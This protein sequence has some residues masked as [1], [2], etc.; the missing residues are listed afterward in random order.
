M[1]VINDSSGTNQNL[2]SITIPDVIKYGDVFSINITTTDSSTPIVVSTNDSTI[3][4]INLSNNEITIIKVGTA[5]LTVTQGNE[6]ITTSSLTVEKKDLL[7]NV[8]SKSMV[9]GSN[10]PSFNSSFTGFVFGETSMILSGNFLYVITDS[11]SNVISSSNLPTSS[12]GT[13]TITV[14]MGTISSSKYNIIINTDIANLTI[15]KKSLSINAINTSMNY[16]ANV[17]ALVSY[18]G[19][20]NGDSSSSLS[21]E[22]SYSNNF[23]SSTNAGS[24]NFSIS[25]GSL[26][27]LNYSITIV[28]SSAILT[29][30]KVNLSISALVN[31][32]MAYGANVPVLV[33]H[34][35]FVNGETLSNLSG[36]L[37]YAIT[38]STTPPNIISYSNLSNTNSGSYGFVVSIGSLASSNY[39]INIVSPNSGTLV[40]NSISTSITNPDVSAGITYGSSLASFISGTS[41]LVNGSPISGT[42]TFR[43]GSS[44]GAILTSA[45]ILS[46][47]TNVYISFVPT[48]SNY[49]SSNKTVPITI[50]KYTPLISF[51]DPLA[52]TTYGTRI[53]EI[54]L[55]AVVAQLNGST[56]P[57]TISFRLDTSSGTLINTGTNNIPPVINPDGS[58]G[59]R[60]IVAI[61]TPSNT[62]LYNSASVSKNVT[63]NKGIIS[64][65]IN[66][67]SVLNVFVGQA[68]PTIPF[69]YTGFVSPDTFDNSISGTPTYIF[70]DGNQNL[71]PNA[72]VPS[73]AAG[74]YYIY[75]SIGSLTSDKYVFTQFP[76]TAYNINKYKVSVSYILATNLKTF[77]YGT[78]LTADYFTAT[79]GAAENGITPS[80]TINYYTNKTMMPLS[81]GSVID[82]DVT[83]LY[84]YFIPHSSVNTIYNNVESTRIT[85]TVNPLSP[86]VLSYIIPENLRNISY[87]T[88]L[89]AE[90]LNARATYNGVDITSTGR[91]TYRTSL[92]DTNTVYLIG[93]KLPAGTNTLYVFYTNDTNNYTSSNTTDAT[94]TTITVTQ[95]SLNGIIRQ[96]AYNML[97]STNAPVFTI[98]WT[99]FASGDN[100]IISIIGSPIYVI[101][102]S[103]NNDVT[104]TIQTQNI[105]AYVVSAS[106]GTLASSNYILTL[107]SATTNLNINPATP[108]LS[109]S[110]STY[111]YGDIAYLNNMNAV[112]NSLSVS[113]IY[114]LRLT[115]ASGSILNTS[116]YI[117]VGQSNIIYASFTP[118]SSNYLP[119]IQT[120]SNIIVTKATPI[121]SYIP[122]T[123]S[124]NY[125][126]TLTAN[127]L[128]AVATLNDITV[129]GSFTYTYTLNSNPS[130]TGTALSSTILGAGIYTL[131]ATFVPTD[132]S[133]FESSTTVSFSTLTVNKI[134]LTVSISTNIVRF[135]YGLNVPQSISYS[136]LGFV[137]S[138][139][140][141]IF[142]GQTPDFQVSSNNPQT[143]LITK[144]NLA[145][146]S[147]GTGYFIN[148]T[149]GTLISNNYN[150]VFGTVRSCY[151]EKANPT[152]TI[153]I[154]Q[155][156]RTFD[157]GT[158][159]TSSYFNGVAKVKDVN[160]NDVSITGTF[161]FNDY[162]KGVVNIGI[163]YLFNSG[164]QRIQCSFNPTDS[165]KYNSGWSN[166]IDLTVN[167]ITPVITYT[168]P[169]NFKSINYGSVF[170]S[171]QLNAVVTYN[172]VVVNTGTITYKPNSL[173]SL[174]NY[175][176][177]SYPTSDLIRI[178]A[179]FTD[180]NNNYNSVSAFDTITVN[181]NNATLT[182]K[183]PILQNIAYGTPLSN[184]QLCA[185]TFN[186]PNNSAPGI[187]NYSLSSNNAS[188]ALGQVLDVGTYVIKAIL[189][190]TNPNYILETLMIQNTLT[191]V[192]NIPSINWANPRDVVVGTAL[193]STQL[194]AV[195]SV[196]NAVS[197]Y[198]PVSGTVMNSATTS[199][200][201]PVELNVLATYDNPNFLF[202]SISTKVKLNVNN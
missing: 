186:D 39:N 88:V 196:S 133:N 89:T 157:Y 131:T 107:S 42:F 178:Y 31:V 123:Q 52:T 148:A 175:T 197:T 179:I 128:N 92:T 36:V 9:Y 138:D 180:S 81:V 185:Q 35:G 200:T 113:G 106:M 188:I 23:S 66:N 111:V 193:S 137:N 158:G 17:P 14:S 28:S 10:A 5:T 74:S 25:I 139:T 159:L 116:N 191:I 102:D 168:I 65:Q 122:T 99:G 38:D 63:I 27:S 103:L 32:S 192:K 163:G 182:W 8:N 55:S 12:V 20:V 53:G 7:V 118:T 87:G 154:A 170:V 198:T 162:F 90:Q 82:A 172:G 70:K 4:S 44:N 104:S 29:I 140:S 136:Y 13:Y 62:T 127:N 187:I 132:T 46:A 177:S 189:V 183:Y 79:Y 34:S 67:R 184:Y 3:F 98:D 181:T 150:F 19:F 145:S 6:S 48:S 108:V 71:I 72:N 50:N 41:V 190:V 49:I 201:G 77:N 37:S 96:T 199:Q 68:I 130:I 59:T 85:I 114:V 141:T 112:Y 155:N 195:V 22:L 86:V 142:S 73:L 165:S 26:D 134:D 100:S 60:T 58:I 153:T 174:T 160:N 161:V 47:T 119:R 97:Y 176:T 94:N 43:S 40:I 83:S 147:V 1:T 95:S 110:T 166:I 164:A 51:N 15:T 146:S 126:D 149:Q 91:I 54:V 30:N 194:N 129:N 121:L 124:Y 57:G 144:D 93:S 135:Y 76:A 61:F 167:K 115:N 156:L 33:S 117:P 171:S 109:I 75:A 120:I 56:I 2:T 21:G 69:N 18:S 173:S 143:T 101:K 78:A 24:N 16:G 202:D 80:G 84:A 105:G 151:I 64:T 45:S 125:G 11:S 169:S 152:V